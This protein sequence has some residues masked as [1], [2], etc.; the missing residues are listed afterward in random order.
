M[1]T[2]AN[3]LRSISAASPGQLPRLDSSRSGAVFARIIARDNLDFFRNRSLPLNS[4]FP[5]AIAYIESLNGIVKIYLSA[6]TSRHVSGDDLIELMGAV[7]R[8]V[9]VT[10]ELVDEFLPTISK[11]DPKYDVRMDGLKR[12][13]EGLGGVVNGEA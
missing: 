8:T 9:Q 7:L 12:M 11:D 1:T 2:A 3:A 6:F 10:L 4:R 5:A 13:R